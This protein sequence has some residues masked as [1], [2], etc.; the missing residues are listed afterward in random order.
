MYCYWFYPGRDHSED[1]TIP[2][3]FTKAVSIGIAV[4]QPIRDALLNQN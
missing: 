4:N 1:E 2:E 3:P